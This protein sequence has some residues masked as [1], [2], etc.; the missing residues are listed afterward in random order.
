MN[1]ERFFTNFSQVLDPTGSGLPVLGPLEGREL[2]DTGKAIVQNTFVSQPVEIRFGPRRPEYLETVRTA[3]R[4]FNDKA[5]LYCTLFR[6]SDGSRTV[7]VTEGAVVEIIPNSADGVKHHEIDGIWDGTLP[8]E[9]EISATKVVGVYYDVDEEGYVMAG[10]PEV[11]SV[12]IGV[13]DDSLHYTPPVGPSPGAVGWVF[14]S[15]VKLIGSGDT[16]RLQVLGGGDNIYHYHDTPPFE[17]ASGSVDIF[18]EYNLDDGRY[19]YLGLL[20]IPPINVA[21]N[22]DDVEFS[23]IGTRDLDLIVKSRLLVNDG[24]I[25]TEVPITIYGAS[26][27]GTT[28]EAPDHS[29]SLDGLTADSA[30]S[31]HTHNFSDTQPQGS[32]FGTFGLTGLDS[33]GGEDPAPDGA[34]THTIS[35]GSGGT[36][37][38]GAHSHTVTVTGDITTTAT[39]KLPSLSYFKTMPNYY[40][41]CWR[42]GIYVG[43]FE[44]EAELPP[45]SGNGLDTKTIYVLNG[46]YSQLDFSNASN[47]QLIPPI[48]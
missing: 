36:G 8:K 25:D 34:H 5:P 10:T 19:Y 27:T 22:G 45:P 28:D 20:G 30:G 7:T 1:P 33:V 35:G 26:L 21:V 11:L 46:E 13:G 18:K 16:E 41:L 24:P 48:T 15:L 32:N 4:L 40:T 12:D 6:K 47:S 37:D 23:W 31:E 2:P 14:V 39:I 44:N 42:A 9:H 38:G 3:P 43:V 29:H 17:C